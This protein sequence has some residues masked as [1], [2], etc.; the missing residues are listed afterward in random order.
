MRSKEPVYGDGWVLH[1]GHQHNVVFNFVEGSKVD[2]CK[3]Q[4]LEGKGY[5][6][7]RNQQSVVDLQVVFH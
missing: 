6:S 1:S 7:V 4:N 2:D 3:V 5:H